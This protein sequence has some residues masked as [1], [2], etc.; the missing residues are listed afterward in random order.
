MFDDT[1]MERYRGTVGWRPLSQR[2]VT[3]L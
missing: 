2:L 3:F 1:L